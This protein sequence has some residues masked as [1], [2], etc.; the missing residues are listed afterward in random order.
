MR[1]F[2]KYV[3]VRLSTLIIRVLSRVLSYGI[4]NVAMLHRSGNRRKHTAKNLKVQRPSDANGA[5]GELTAKA[6]GKAN[7]TKVSSERIL[8]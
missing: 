6:A 1:T 5:D 8:E 2:A 3:T 7:S 4:I